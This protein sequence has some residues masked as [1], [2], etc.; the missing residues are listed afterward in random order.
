MK[1]EQNVLTEVQTEQQQ[2]VFPENPTT[3]A[4]F[5]VG[6]TFLGQEH[7]SVSRAAYWPWTLPAEIRLYFPKREKHSLEHILNTV[8]FKDKQQNVW[9]NVPNSSSFIK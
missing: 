3:V 7:D 1:R 9:E 5:R 6:G 4:P 8:Q 2:Q